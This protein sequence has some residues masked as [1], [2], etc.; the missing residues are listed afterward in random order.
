VHL[1]RAEAA[2]YIEDFVMGSGDAWDW[3]DF[4]SIPLDD[5]ELD[6][7]RVQCATMPDR[8]P[9]TR[10]RQ[11]CNENGTAELRRLAETLKT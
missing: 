1:S 4:I 6:K 7:I 2:K 10:P 8:Y 3:D 11:Y 9:P 5:P